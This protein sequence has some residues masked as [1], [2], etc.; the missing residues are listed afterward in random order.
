MFTVLLPLRPLLFALLGLSMLVALP[1]SAAAPPEDRAAQVTLCLKLRRDEPV[2][3]VALA[4]RLLQATDLSLEDELKTLSCLGIAAGLSGEPEQ[5]LIAAERMERRVGERPDLAP[6]LKMRAYSHAGSIYQ[7]AGHI[8]AA[9]AAYL[10][11][12]EVASRLDAH[13]AALV[14]AATLTNIGLIHADYLDSPDVA[15]EYYRK[16][17][18]IAATVDLE[19]PVIVH[20]HALNLVALGRT[21]EALKV[22]AQGEAMAE[23][24]QAHAVV[25]RLRAERAGLWIR[26]GKLAQA[27][28]LLDAAILSQEASKDFPGL[29]GSLAKRSILQRQAGD[30][31][32]ALATAQRA[33]SLVEGQPQPQKQREVLLA[34]MAAHA[35]LGEADKALAVGSRLHGMEMESLKQQRLELLADLQARSESAD[36]QRELEQMRHEAQISALNDDKADL[37]RRAG[38]ALLGLLVV[39]GVGFGLL[40]RRKN[41]QL[42]AVSATDPLTG[43]RNRRAAGDALQ[44]MSAQRASP[45]MRH[46]LFLIDIDHFKK[47]NDSFG[48]HAGDGVLVDIADALRALCRPGDVIAR[49]G[50]EEFLMACPDLTAAQACTVAA[51][52]H[53]RLGGARELA[54]GRA[55]DL[56]VSLGFA[57]FPFFEEGR[58][59]WEYAIRLADRALYAAKDRRNAWAGLWGRSLPEGTS[60]AAVLEEPENAV[61][62]GHV[63]LMASYAIERLPKPVLR[64]A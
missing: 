53:E 6:D 30:A 18:A 25:D 1:S 52:L 63:D 49:W 59:S 36:A 40:Q 41:R 15:D 8:H 24:K 34:W 14:Q 61:R 44:A 54:P 47:V 33:W 3:A 57:P 62:S 28:S 58:E 17:L 35:A 7:G 5:A 13:D 42:R 45:G 16:A 64:A 2:K 22:I 60:A 46:V 9:E 20:N 29:A 37:V 55:W 23:R 51:R 11:A 39:A 48:H 4:H 19:D 27:K 38:G 32:G 43:L 56:T 10:R 26:Q 31:R 21:T 50:G 12:F